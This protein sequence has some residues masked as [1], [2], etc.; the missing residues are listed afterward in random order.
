MTGSVSIASI[1]EHTAFTSHPMGRTREQIWLVQLTV[2]QAMNVTFAELCAPTR[3]KPMAALARQ[4]AMYLC[5]TVFSVKVTETARAFC[6]DPS[7]VSHALRRIEDLRDNPEFDRALNT[8]ENK[9]QIIW[10]D[11]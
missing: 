5:H 8:L 2:S 9:L 3:Q 7:T 1:C 4:M 11:A 10:G 6:R